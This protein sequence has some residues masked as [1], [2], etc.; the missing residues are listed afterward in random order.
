[1]TSAI[2]VNITNAPAR[3]R[4]RPILNSGYDKLVKC[5]ILGVALLAAMF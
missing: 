5:W 2:S 3:R 4:Y 1:M